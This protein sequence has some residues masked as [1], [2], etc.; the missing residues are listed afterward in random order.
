MTTD[1][2]YEF[3]R[4]VPVHTLQIGFVGQEDFL[5][6]RYDPAFCVVVFDL[7]SRKELNGLSLEEHHAGQECAASGDSGRLSMVRNTDGTR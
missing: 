6:L 5:R 4:F 1:L 2:A 7:W 3:P